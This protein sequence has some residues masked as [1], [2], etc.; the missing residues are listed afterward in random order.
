MGGRSSREVQTTV[1]NND[2]W[3]GAQ[4]TM[5][6]ALSGAQNLYNT[7]QGFQTYQGPR[8]AGQSGDTLAAQSG[9][10]ALARG[11]MGGAGLSGQYQDV[12]NRGGLTAAQQGAMGGFQNLASQG[13]LSADQRQA[14]NRTNELAS[15]SYSVSPELQRILDQSNEDAASQVRL[16][17][18][19]AGRYGSGMGNAAIADAVSRNT[20]NLIYSDLNN[21]RSRQDAANQ[22]AF[23]MGQMGQGNMAA[24][25][26]NIANLG[27]TGFG[28]LGTAFTGMQAPAQTLMGVGGMQDARAQQ[29]IEADIGRFDDEQ[30][31]ARERVSFL[32]GI[33]SGAG[34]LGGSSTSRVS[35]PG[36]NRLMQGLGYGLSGA[37]L[38]GGL[39]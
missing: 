28:N 36:P 29:M 6:M 4:P 9:L 38:L 7:G 12:I 39:F 25:Y 16:A 37:G 33:G 18:S 20:G 8:V 13:G 15:A 35:Q 21:F 17:N 14:L 3:A 26:G 34:A 2:P 27:Q 1:N 30:T 31:R 11:N 10:S 32:S 19:S 22:N 23:Q 5:N 24:A